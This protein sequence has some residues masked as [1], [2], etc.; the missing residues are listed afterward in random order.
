MPD[1]VEIAICRTFKGGFLSETKHTAPHISP[2][3]P[4]LPTIA[5]RKA[6][7]NARREQCPHSGLA[8]DRNYKSGGEGKKQ[9][10]DTDTH[11]RIEQ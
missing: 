6:I 11:S 4:D 7:G 9:W 1:D 5:E 8:V 2:A 10:P 3:R